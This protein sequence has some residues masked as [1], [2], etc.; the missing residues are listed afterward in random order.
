MRVVKLAIVI[1]TFT[2]V[3][4]VNAQVNNQS[5]HIIDVHVAEVALIDIYDSEVLA[6]GLESTDIINLDLADRVGV[7]ESGLYL[8]SGISRTGLWLNYTSVVGTTASGFDTVRTIDV[9]MLTNGIGEAFPKS[10][11]LVIQP[12]N[13]LIVNNGGNPGTPVTDVRLGET[14]AL[15]T[16]ARLVN[17]IG[18]VHTGDG[19]KGI[20]LTYSLVQNG[21]FANYKAGSY[22]AIIEYTLSDL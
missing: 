13:A 17:G 1:L 11:D 22:S 4:K 21:D 12:G 15:G 2:L 3:N 6:K 16:N 10:V 18:S 14:N 19:A 8:F 20:P 7:S 5:S 9:K